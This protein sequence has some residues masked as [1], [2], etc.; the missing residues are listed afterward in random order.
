MFYFYTI[1]RLI[2]ATLSNSGFLPVFFSSG[3]KFVKPGSLSAIMILPDSLTKKP[4]ILPTLRLKKPGFF[5]KIYSRLED[6]IGE[7]FRW[8]P[9]LK[10]KFC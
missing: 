10:F 3:R 6:A 4:G 8:R 9:K 2:L 5:K 1:E 7:I